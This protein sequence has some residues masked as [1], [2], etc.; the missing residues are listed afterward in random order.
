M[1]SDFVCKFQRENSQNHNSISDK[2]SWSKSL[3]CRLVMA[4]DSRIKICQNR[5]EDIRSTIWIA[6][7][8]IT[9][10]QANVCWAPLR[11]GPHACIYATERACLLIYGDMQQNCIAGLTHNHTNFAS[12]RLHAIRNVYRSIASSF[13]WLSSTRLTQVDMHVLEVA[14]FKLG[15]SNGDLYEFSRSCCIYWAKDEEDVSEKRTGLFQ[16]LM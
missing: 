12:V 8:Y 13:F 15:R 14:N 11:G 2:K 4:S 1:R 5:P 9:V 3:T 10:C 6:T 7:K 16:G